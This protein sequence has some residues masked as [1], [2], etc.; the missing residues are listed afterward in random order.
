MLLEYTTFMKGV[1]VADQLRASDSSQSRSHKWWHRIFFALLDITEV[2][3][4]VMYLDRCKQGP[5]PITQPMTHL[6][7]KNALCEALLVGWV[8]RNE[9]Q[10]GPLNHHPTIYMPLHSTKKRLCVVC[11]IWK[12]HTYCYHCGYKFMC[13]KEGCY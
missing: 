2:N 9:V 5:S 1:D 3:I 13:C 6:Q 4:Y 10:D 7:F 11:K 8:R 12:P